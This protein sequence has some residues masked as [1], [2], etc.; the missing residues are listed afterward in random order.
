MAAISANI[1]QRGTREGVP[2]RAQR[3]VAHRVVIRIEQVPESWM[4]GPITRQMFGQKERLKEPCGVCQVPLRRTRIGHGLQ[5]MI[6]DRQGRA[7]SQRRLPNTA[8]CLRQT[9]LACNQNRASR[10]SS[11]RCTFHYLLFG[12][13]GLKF[14]TLPDKMPD[15]SR[16]CKF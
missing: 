12:F 3:A 11:C 5:V 15:I 2:Q 13:G 9:C 7:T 8:K 1:I 16:S 10:V 4:E 14:K 6:F